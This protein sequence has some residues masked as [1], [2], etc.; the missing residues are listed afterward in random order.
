LRGQGLLA[1]GRSRLPVDRASL[2]RIIA[3]VSAWVARA[4]W[5]AELDINPLIVTSDGPLAVDA[6]IRLQPPND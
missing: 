2:A 5:L 4:P 6:R 1:G 3:R